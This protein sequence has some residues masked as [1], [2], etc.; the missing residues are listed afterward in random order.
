MTVKM[1]R[2]KMHLVLAGALALAAAALLPLVAAHG[3]LQWPE[4]R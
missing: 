4:S 1:A 3:Y 2:S